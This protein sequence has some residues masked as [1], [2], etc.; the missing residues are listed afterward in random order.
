MERISPVYISKQEKPLI[1]RDSTFED[2]IGIFG[3]A[4][5]IDSPNF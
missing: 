1:V 3:G 2:N 4:I 5:L